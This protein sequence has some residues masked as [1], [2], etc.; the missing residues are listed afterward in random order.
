MAMHTCAGSALCDW[1]PHAA[2]VPTNSDTAQSRNTPRQAPLPSLSIPLRHITSL[3]DA[4]A[5]IE[6]LVIQKRHAMRHTW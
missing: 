5:Q 1:R 3:H 6:A 2:P 4:Q